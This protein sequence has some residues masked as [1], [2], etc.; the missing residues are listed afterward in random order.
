MHYIHESGSLHR[1]LKPCNVM[2][3]EGG[4]IIKLGDF[5]L[6]VDIGDKGVIETST[7]VRVSV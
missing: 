6:A 4:D 5:G 1:D 2:L 7:E 3:T